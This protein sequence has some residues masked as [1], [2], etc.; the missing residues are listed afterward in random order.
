MIIQNGNGQP[1]SLDY[2]WAKVSQRSDEFKGDLNLS[3][4]VKISGYNWGTSF[5]KPELVGTKS[6]FLGNSVSP[7]IDTSIYIGL[8]R[9]Y[10]TSDSSYHYY[11]GGIVSVD[12]S[13]KYGYF[14]FEAKVPTGKGIWPCFWIWGANGFSSYSEID[15]F[16]PGPIDFYNNKNVSG[17]WYK[18]RPECSLSTSNPNYKINCDVKV[19]F[20]KI[21]DNI[22]A[23]YHK[24]AVEWLKDTLIF[25]V[26]DKPY[27]CSI[28]KNHQTGLLGSIDSSY[29]VNGKTFWVN[30]IVSVQ[31]TIA[32]ADP[33]R[34]VIDL[35][36]G[37][38]TVLANGLDLLNQ[39]EFPKFMIVRN[40]RY[41]Q[42][43]ESKTDLIINS[44]S[45]FDFTARS[46]YS[47]RNS[48]KLSNCMVPVNSKVT[49]RANNFINMENEFVVPLGCEFNASITKFKRNL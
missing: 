49:F 17:Y 35:Q 37:D 15:I 46:N 20:S 9:T 30:K 42:L 5:F 21:I 14:E 29:T 33:M 22:G 38:R 19:E 31:D 12:H 32:P 6:F 26:D 24:Y 23:D 36:T 16:E 27:G 3:K 48:V 25:Y 4:W 45:S 28:I 8:D 2:N 11:T 18:W 39:N 43:K 41:Y 47:V 7:D 34:I 10:Q 40:F 13:Y 44:N 1:P